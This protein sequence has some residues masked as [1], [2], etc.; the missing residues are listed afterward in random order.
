MLRGVYGR[1]ARRTPH[2]FATLTIL[3]QLDPG[4]DREPGGAAGVLCDM[5]DAELRRRVAAA[6]QKLYGAPML[7]GQRVAAP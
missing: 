5:P 7:P 4:A 6:W 2:F 1:G 3:R